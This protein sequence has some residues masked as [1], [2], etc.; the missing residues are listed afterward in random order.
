MT[1]A[2]SNSRRPRRQP[3]RPPTHHGLALRPRRRRHQD[4]EVAPHL[5]LPLRC[6]NELR[7]HEP[8]R[9]PREASPETAGEVRPGVRFR[10][11]HALGRGERPARVP[12]DRGSCRANGR[13]M[14]AP[15]VA[16]QL[17]LAALRWRHADRTDLAA[18]RPQRNRGD[19]DSS[20]ASRSDRS[21]TTVRPS[22]T[23]SSTVRGRS[24]SVG[25][26]ASPQRQRP[27]GSSG[28]LWPG[29]LWSAIQDLN[30]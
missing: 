15:R 18:R 6:V 19:R 26:A 27:G 24:H 30:Q 8:V 1:W 25:H 14:D 23:G 2:M 5:A 11:R 29:R 13:R 12:T 10:G 7:A 21:S 22:W 16:A 4:P 20:T 9:R 17:R 3:A 28:S